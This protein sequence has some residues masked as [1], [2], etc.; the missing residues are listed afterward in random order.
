[1]T[2]SI[3][4]FHIHKLSCEKAGINF[5]HLLINEFSWWIYSNR[6]VK[7]DYASYIKFVVD[8]LPESM[9]ANYWYGRNCQLNDKP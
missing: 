7:E 4:A 6:K 9:R 5:E 1:M 3:N 8:E 2:G